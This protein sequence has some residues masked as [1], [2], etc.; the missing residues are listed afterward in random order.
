MRLDVPCEIVTDPAHAGM[1]DG[2]D[3]DGITVVDASSYEWPTDAP[4]PAADPQPDSLFMLIFTSG[5]SGDPKAVRITHEKI[6]G[7]AA[8]LTERLGL[9][10]DDVHYIAMP[11]FH[12]N[13]V[14]AGWA[15]AVHNGAAIASELDAM[16]PN[17][18]TPTSITPEAAREEINAIPLNP[19]GAA[20]QR[21]GVGARC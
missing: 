11:L 17:G 8:Y 1:L 5:T 3:L 2:L 12:A 19:D 16:Q 21:R 6:T 10:S 18:G 15:P 13:G 9:T 20:R 7:P 14:I 4:A